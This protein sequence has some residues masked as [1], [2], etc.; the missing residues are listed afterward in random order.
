MAWAG[1][2]VSL[3]GG[4]VSASGKASEGRKAQKAFNLNAAISTENAQL[5]REAADEDILSL[6]RTAYKTE[7]GIRA[8]YG[9]SGVSGGSGS[10]LDVLADSMA[11]ATLDQNRRKYQGELEARD[12]MNQAAQGISSGRSAR[13]AGEY[14]AAGQVLSS[15]GSAVS[16]MYKPAPE[17]KPAPKK[18]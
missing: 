8:G 4:L 12:F 5:A 2:V 13:V 16:S 17:K 6:K 7:G 15:T 11:Q 14:A 3:I 10:S 1:A 18:K 9:A